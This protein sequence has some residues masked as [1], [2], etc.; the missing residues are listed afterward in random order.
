MTKGIK[1]LFF[2]QFL[3][4]ALIILFLTSC[5]VKDIYGCTKCQYYDFDA[6]VCKN[7]KCCSDSDCNNGL[8]CL[9]AGEKNADCVDKRTCYDGTKQD[10]CSEYENG[11]ACYFSKL[12]D[13]CSLC[14]CAKGFKCA[15]ESCVKYKTAV[16]LVHGFSDSHYVWKNFEDWFTDDGIND[17]YDIDLV[18]STGNITLLS[19]QVSAKVNEIINKT[20]ADKVDIVAH[21]MGGLVVREYTNSNDYGN[22]I[23][24]FIMIATPNQ[25]VLISNFDVFFSLNNTIA[26]KQMSSG[27]AFIRKLNSYPLNDNISYFIIAGTK[28]E[29]YGFLYDGLVLETETLLENVSYT[30]FPLSHFELIENP[31][32]YQA[33]KKKLLE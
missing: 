32:V 27:S 8:K 33:V 18:P 24:K 21:S 15:E 29:S 17:V 22:D 23:N 10:E 30:S 25:G 1:L 31:D 26:T 20:G 2:V 19:K 9:F 3:V 7:A 13:S 4:L 28:Y 11:K 16:L 12:L 6:G 14:S 5:T